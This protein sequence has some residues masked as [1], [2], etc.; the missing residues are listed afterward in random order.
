MALR[1]PERIHRRTVSASRFVRR[2]ASGTVNI[3][4][5][6]YYNACSPMLDNCELPLSSDELLP[7]VLEVLPDGWDLVLIDRQFIVTKP[8]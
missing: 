2:A 4:A 3:V 5:A 1:R 8:A 7:P 6:Y